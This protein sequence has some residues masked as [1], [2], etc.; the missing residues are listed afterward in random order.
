MFGTWPP[1][2]R[3]V[4][5]GSGLVLRE[6]TADDIASLTALYDTFEMDQRTPVAA[7]FDDE[8]ARRYVEDA[9]RRREERTALQLAITRDGVA[10]IGELLVAATDA[11]D[12]VE[13]A[14]AVAAGHT[15]AGVARRA[16]LTVLAELARTGIARAVLLI[17]DDNVASQ[18]V[19][20]AA[21]FSQ[22]D[23]PFVER[24]T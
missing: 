14:Y 16:V 10:P 18:R 17:T 4:L 24:K 23:D 7:P 9:R 21:G 1:A 15:G 22:T 12:T 11:L 19:A 20:R 6:W 2:D 5:I 3:V 13:L 8:A